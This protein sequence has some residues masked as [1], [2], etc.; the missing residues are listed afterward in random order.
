MIQTYIFDL[1]DTIIDKSIYARIYTPIIESLL[2]TLKI[3]KIELQEIITKI[4]EETGR[5]KVDTFELCKKLNSTELYYKVLKRYVKHT[6]SLKTKNISKV[7]KKINASKKKIGVV[8]KSEK[9]TIELFLKRFNLLE[10]VDFIEPGNKNTVLYW[11]LLE[12]KY[13]LDKDQTMVIDDSNE[14]LD[15]AEHAG[16][17]VLNVKDLDNIEG[18][19]Y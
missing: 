7:F 10:Y 14:I 16:Y 5:E 6:Y 9:R 18:F 17:K 1:E 4:K 15:I 8:S 12:K 11:V 13:K 2:E 19:S 3:S